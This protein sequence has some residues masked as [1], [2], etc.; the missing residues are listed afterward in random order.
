MYMYVLNDYYIIKNAWIKKKNKE[1]K[2][3][4][5]TNLN[6]DIIYL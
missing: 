5:S 1:K 2:N 4:K 6:T 3:L